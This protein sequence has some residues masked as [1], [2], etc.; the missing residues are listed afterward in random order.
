MLTVGIG[1]A[2]GPASECLSPN[3]NHFPNTCILTTI[4]LCH[5]EEAEEESETQMEEGGGAGGGGGGPPLTCGPPPV[6][7][8][9]PA[10]PPPP[11]RRLRWQARRADALGKQRIKK[12]VGLSSQKNINS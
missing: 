3:A 4:S 6:A 1:L 8:P 12:W 10:P 7:P 5:F 2:I 11:S 9:S